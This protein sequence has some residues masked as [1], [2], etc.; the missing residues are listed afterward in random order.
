MSMDPFQVELRRVPTQDRQFQHTHNIPPLNAILKSLFFH[1]PQ[2]SF[3]PPYPCQ[4]SP[5]DLKGQRGNHVDSKTNR[6]PHDGS[7]LH[8]S[9]VNR[10]QTFTL[11]TTMK[12][13]PQG[14]PAI[15]YPPIGPYSAAGYLF[16][17][18][19][20]RNIALQCVL[21]SPSE[22]TPVNLS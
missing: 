19:V 8:A 5:S 15:Y 6:A 18:V 3:L 14:N 13:C 21:I 12:G 11:F 2:I 10:T 7:P 4:I 9:R 16:C 22:T 20:G 1:F 17:P